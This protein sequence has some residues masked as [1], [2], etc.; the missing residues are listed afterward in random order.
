MSK[1]V[2][3]VRIIFFWMSFCVSMYQIVK[4]TFFGDTPD[5]PGACYGDQAGLKLQ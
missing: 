2:N 5:S 1:D 3:F 4:S